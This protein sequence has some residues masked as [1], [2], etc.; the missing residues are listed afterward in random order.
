MTMADLAAKKEVARIV[1]AP[2]AAGR[3]QIRRR[4][5]PARFMSAVIIDSVSAANSVLYASVDDTT[6]V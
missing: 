5:F 4:T 1:V 2:K 3:I 6:S